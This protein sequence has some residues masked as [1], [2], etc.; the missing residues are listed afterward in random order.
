M[1]TKQTGFG[2][3]GERG[4][5]G[6]ISYGCMGMQM[7]RMRL[8]E[9]FPGL[10]EYIVALPDEAVLQDDF[11][12]GAMLAIFALEENR[13]AAVRGLFVTRHGCMTRAEAASLD[14]VRAK[15]AARRVYFVRSEHSGFIKIGVTGDLRK[16][17]ANLQNAS[18]S[19]LRILATEP[20]G[21]A[22]EQALHKR[23]EAYQIR[24]E[25]FK[26]GPELLDYI[27]AVQP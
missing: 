15:E 5:G 12:I 24:G 22:H 23:F 4:R 6:S 8:I 27:A 7:V 21:L 17:V 20:G 16:R 2:F 13:K 9:K 10:A 19:V 18:G 26:P 3:E 25:W 1:T 11:T 14:D